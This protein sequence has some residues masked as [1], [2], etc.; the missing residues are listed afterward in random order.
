MHSTIAKEAIT[1]IYIRRLSA[2]DLYFSD[3]DGE[4]ATALGSVVPHAEKEE[5]SWSTSL[6]SD[7]V[8]ENEV[9]VVRFEI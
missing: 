6:F 9:L 3:S 7:I 2:I 8:Y 1:V 4:R 5:S